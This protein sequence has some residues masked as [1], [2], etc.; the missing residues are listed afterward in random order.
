MKVTE[1]DIASAGGSPTA[2]LAL[3]SCGC[4]DPIVVW[5][6]FGEE[7]SGRMKGKNESTPFLLTV[8]DFCAVF[9]GSKAQTVL[10]DH[11]LSS[12]GKRQ[13]TLCSP[14]NRARP[15]IPSLWSLGCILVQKAICFIAGHSR[16]S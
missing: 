5:W 6:F 10:F 2:R 3:I 14:T 11:H 7:G 15:Q 4:G 8:T 12:R 9:S 1:G 13:I 16:E